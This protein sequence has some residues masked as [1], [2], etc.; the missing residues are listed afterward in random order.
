MVS[1]AVHEVVAQID[2]GGWIR[3]ISTSPDGSVVFASASGEDHD[4]IWVIDAATNSVVTSI[5]LPGD[6][7]R[8]LFS[9]DGAF[10]YAVTVVGPNC[11]GCEDDGR[12][13][14]IDTTDKTIQAVIDL[15]AAEMDRVGSGGPRRSESDQV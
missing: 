10:A 6:A 2:L 7:S 14:V 12:V 9:P 11:S 8:I 3:T 15:L 1:T 5:E 13:Y 4:D